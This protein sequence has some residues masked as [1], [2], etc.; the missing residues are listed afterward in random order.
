[1]AVA[2]A[3]HDGA[4]R[5]GHTAGQA[6][7]DQA[8]GQRIVVPDKATAQVAGQQVDGIGGRPC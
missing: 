6:D 7:P 8:G 5:E 3:Q 1:M 4:S 2:A